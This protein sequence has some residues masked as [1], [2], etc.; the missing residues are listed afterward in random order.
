MPIDLTWDAAVRAYWTGRDLQAQRQIEAGRADAGTRGAVTGGKHL[1][2][3][4]DAVAELF[5]NAEG[6]DFDIRTSGKLTLPGYYRRTKDWDLIVLYRGV[7]VAAIEFKS[8]SGSFG[9]NFNNRTEEAIGNAADIWRAYQEGYLG[10]IRPWLAFVMILEKTPVSTAIQRTAPALFPTD[11]IFNDTSYL[12]RYR[13]L[14]RR[15]L[16][17]QQYDAA[18][19]A[20]TEQGQGIYDEPDFELSFANFGAAIK[21]RIEYIRALPDSAFDAG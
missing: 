18:V 9:N 8:Q 13:I 7:L 19:V 21:G 14:L 20:A 17:E 1:D 15:L 12:D 4:R 6:I 11:S 10:P 5:R 16:H 3:M 2:P